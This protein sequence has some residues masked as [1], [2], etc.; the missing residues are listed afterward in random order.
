MEGSPRNHCIINVAVFTARA[1]L[2]IGFT[3][4]RYSLQTLPVLSN[5]QQPRALNPRFPN[6]LCALN[7]CAEELEFLWLLVIFDR[8][9]QHNKVAT[10][11]P[12]TLSCSETMNVPCLEI[13]YRLEIPSFVQV[14][15]LVGLV[16]Y[17]RVTA[18]TPGAIRDSVCLLYTSDA[19]D[20]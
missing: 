18:C 4:I 16:S 13:Y 17:V 12:T 20:E 8:R 7:A 15:W 14:L 6:N 19:A 1:A 11:L 2:Y 3:L 9:M 5:N 10:I